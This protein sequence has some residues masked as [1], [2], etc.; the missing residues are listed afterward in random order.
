M[1]TANPSA[2]TPAAPKVFRPLGFGLRSALTLL[3]LMA[4][5]S[6]ASAAITFDSATASKAKHNTDEMS[7]KHTIG[8]G[9]DA[10]VVVAVSFNDLL[11][12]G[13]Q[14]TSV[15]LG[16]VQM[17]PVPYSLARSSGLG[18]QTTTQLFYLDGAEAPAP[19][20]YEVSVAFTGKVV[21]AA[22][23]AVSLFGVE[24]GAPAAVA[25]N[26][27]LL[28]LGQI[29]TDINAP[30]YSWVVDVAA[31]ASGADL[32]AGPGQTERFGEAKKE[33]GIAGSAQAAA[34]GVPTTLFW[35]QA[36]LTQLVTSAVAFAAKPVF[37]LSQA[38]T[39][40]G[41]IQTSTGGDMFHK[42]EAVTLTAVPAVG[43]EFAGWS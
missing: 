13:N 15:R 27:N 11:G 6:S 31:S 17:R 12:N 1:K 14:I 36:D 24:P 40:A 20:T 43:W 33:I 26:S 21:E 4:A 38:T 42:G 35:Q 2:N 9:A 39:G 16:G 8:G 30:A 22:G 3:I 34:F 10:A 32:A 25:T 18:V 23:G 37:K 29:S 19:G 28:G 7:W 41:A 5:V